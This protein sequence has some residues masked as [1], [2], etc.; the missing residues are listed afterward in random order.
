[1]SERSLPRPRRRHR[2]FPRTLADQPTPKAA[3]ISSPADF[4][5]GMKPMRMLR[6]AGAL[7]AVVTF[8]AAAGAAERISLSDSQ[9]KATA[10]VRE[11]LR[12]VTARRAAAAL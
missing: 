7:A 6:L 3:K 8:V 5:K 11:F 4:T 9:K 2:P 10:D 1:M 12:R